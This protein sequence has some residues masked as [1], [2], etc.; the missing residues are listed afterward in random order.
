MIARS[1]FLALGEGSDVIVEL[2]EVIVRRFGHSVQPVTHLLRVVL[3]TLGDGRDVSLQR[4]VVV[5][6][7]LRH[8]DVAV[9]QLFLLGLELRT[10]PPRVVLE[11]C[12]VLTQGTQLLLE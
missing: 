3:S 8:R 5:T 2:S 7:G 12:E 10:V 9:V 1:E 11:R 4:R 6:V